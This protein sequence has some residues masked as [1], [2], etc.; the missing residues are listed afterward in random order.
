MSTHK[1][2]KT[3]GNIE[4]RTLLQSAGAMCD[5]QAPCDWILAVQDL[6]V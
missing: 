3:Q 2:S 5:G 4:Y 6:T 1:N